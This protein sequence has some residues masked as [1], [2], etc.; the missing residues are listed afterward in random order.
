M[1]G[2]TRM[3]DNGFIANSALILTSGLVAKDIVEW[4]TTI[5]QVKYS[6]TGTHKMLTFF[7]LLRCSCALTKKNEGSCP[8]IV[9]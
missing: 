1:A 6:Y 8:S 4:R 9:V 7:F 3:R 5:F 2:I